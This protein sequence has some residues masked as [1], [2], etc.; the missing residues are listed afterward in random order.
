MGTNGRIAFGL[1]NNYA[2]VTDL[3]VETL[4]PRDPP[5]MTSAANGGRGSPAGDDQHSRRRAGEITVRSTVHG[6]LVTELTRESTL[7]CR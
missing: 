6:P 3:Y 5:A 2:D 4:D 7:R 1:T